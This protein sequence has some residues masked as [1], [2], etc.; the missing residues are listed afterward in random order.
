M[1]NNYRCIFNKS[2]NSYNN[3]YSEK[4]RIE[5]EQN[6]VNNRNN[7]IYNHSKKINIDYPIFIEYI[8]NEE[9]EENEGDEKDKKL[10]KFAFIIINILLIGMSFYA[11]YYAYT[12]SEVSSI[13]LKMYDSF[14]AFNFGIYYFIH[15]YIRDLLATL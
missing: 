11:G 15:N 4:K 9:D 10:Y 1:C 5:Y 3:D 13:L 14:I 7:K 8:K 12:K 2:K 6:A